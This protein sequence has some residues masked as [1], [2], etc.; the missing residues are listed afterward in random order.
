MKPIS[1]VRGDNVMS[2][3]SILC[4]LCTE[5]CLILNEMRGSNVAV[6]EG[7]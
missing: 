5:L 6:K 7:L 1:G 3:G 4:Q 2:G